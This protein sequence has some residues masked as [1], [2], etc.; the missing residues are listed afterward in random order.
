MSDLAQILIP[1]LGAPSSHLSGDETNSSSED[2]LSNTLP[3]KMFEN[4]KT[5]PQTDLTQSNHF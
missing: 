3:A 2:E 1:E 5:L 4:L